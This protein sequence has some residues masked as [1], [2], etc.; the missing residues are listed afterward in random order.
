MTDNKKNR[1][2]SGITLFLFVLIVLGALWFT[3]TLDS[4]ESH[5]IA[6][7][8]PI[9]NI[10]IGSSTILTIQPVI[11]QTIEAFILPTA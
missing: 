10:I 4:K 8:E 6:G 9:P 7:N 5:P 3:N 2:L 11:R 1:G